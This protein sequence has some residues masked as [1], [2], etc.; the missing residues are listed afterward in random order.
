MAPVLP[1]DLKEDKKIYYSPILKS[2]ICFV[3]NFGI[4]LLYPECVWLSYMGSVAGQLRRLPN[5]K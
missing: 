4:R 2:E 5:S 1:P 3:T